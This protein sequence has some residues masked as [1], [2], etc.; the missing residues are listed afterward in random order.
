[1]NIVRKIEKV[2]I[3]FIVNK[4]LRGT[5]AFNAKRK[6]LNFCDGVIIEDGSRIVTPI[7]L[8]VLSTLYIGKD[9]WIGRDF[10]LEGNGEVVIG[11]NCDLAANIVCAT[12]S[13]EIGSETRR[14]GEGFNGKII[15][16]NGS[17][18]G[19][20]TVLLPNIEIGSGCVVGAAA[21]VTKNLETNAVYVGSPAKKIRNL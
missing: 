16:G 5:H 19:T 18:I 10:F 15:I 13:H 4:M 3:L 21:V 11:A 17:W 2:A 1:M 14:A 9:C 6:L 12:G 8:P 7:H 20:R